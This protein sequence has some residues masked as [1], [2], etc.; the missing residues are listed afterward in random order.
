MR[1]RVT[2]GIIYS[3]IFLEIYIPG[4]E[5][6]YELLA[7]NRE[8]VTFGVSFIKIPSRF[9]PDATQLHAPRIAH[10]AGKRKT[11]WCVIID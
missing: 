10:I 6:F 1:M 5:L 3:Y 2:L 9:S 4:R 7:T 11:F 8:C